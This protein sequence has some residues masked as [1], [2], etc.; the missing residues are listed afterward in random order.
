MKVVEL[1]T[2]MTGKRASN[3]SSG[4]ELKQKNNLAPVIFNLTLERV[5][6]KFPSIPK[7]R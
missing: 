1:I 3:A 5:V 7:E 2:A 6:R 4:I